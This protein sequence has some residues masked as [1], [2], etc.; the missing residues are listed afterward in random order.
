[1]HVGTC[2]M[3]YHVRHS[4]PLSPEDPTPVALPGTESPQAQLWGGGGQVRSEPGHEEDQD[5]VDRW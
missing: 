3:S 5:W 2:A 4:M 1:V